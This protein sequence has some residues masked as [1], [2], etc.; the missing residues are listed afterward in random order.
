MSQILSKSQKTPEKYFRRH[1]AENT[2]SRTIYKHWGDFNPVICSSL[3]S[4]EPEQNGGSP[5]KNN[6]KLRSIHRKPK[7]ELEHKDLH[8][9]VNL[10]IPRLS[11][12][13]YKI[14]PKNIE[15]N[16]QLFVKNTFFVSPRSKMQIFSREEINIKPMPMF[17]TIPMKKFTKNTVEQIWLN[18][19]SKDSIGT[20][21][22]KI[23]KFLLDDNN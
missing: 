23:H 10:E 2:S 12:E 7:K 16:R 6:S 4:S 20:K 3:E 15:E 1:S 11:Y 19:V 21:I 8:P 5:I 14:R 13:S 17:R 9:P 18:K 22:K